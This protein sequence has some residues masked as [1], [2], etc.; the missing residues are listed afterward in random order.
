MTQDVAKQSYRAVLCMSCRQPIPVPAIVITL[1]VVPQ[2]N[3]AG[4]LERTELVFTLRCRA[5]GRERPYRSLEIIELE[6]TPPPRTSYL[7]RPHG[8]RRPSGSLSRAANG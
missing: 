1:G 6:G 7:R 2:G 4:P 8:V 3:E 5:C